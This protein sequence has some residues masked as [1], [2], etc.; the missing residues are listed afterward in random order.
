VK[1]AAQ[2]RKAAKRKAA[3][4]ATSAAAKGAA[5]VGPAAETGL[6]AGASAAEATENAATARTARRARALCPAPAMAAK[7]L[8]GGDL[9]GGCGG[10]VT[11]KLGPGLGSGG[12][13][14]GGGALFIDSGGKRGL[15]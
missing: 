11:D 15:I 3:A 10:R 9:C 6:G 2:W 8:E 13:R 1:A 5:E 14:R 12:E 4:E 7:V